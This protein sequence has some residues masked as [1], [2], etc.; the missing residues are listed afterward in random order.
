MV[1]TESLQEVV[2]FFHSF[3]LEAL[4]LVNR[5]F[6]SL[7]DEQFRAGHLKFVRIDCVDA[8]ENVYELLI[9]RARG[10]STTFSRSEVARTALYDELVLKLSNTVIECMTVRCHMAVS[11]HVHD[12]LAK[13]GPS[14]AV[15]KLLRVYV[16]AYANGEDIVRQLL[17]FHKIA[18]SSHSE[19]TLNVFVTS[20]SAQFSASHVP[21]FCSEQGCT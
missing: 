15:S 21:C 4:L 20:C 13:L 1:P 17:S 19:A 12:V 18:V 2:A 7:A 8:R 10:V 3:N 11:T 9:G 14:L 5:T 6:A 16:G